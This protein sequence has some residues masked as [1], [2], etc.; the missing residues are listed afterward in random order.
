MSA[1]RALVLLEGGFHLAQLAAQLRR[2][3]R[4]GCAAPRCPGAGPAACRGRCW[5]PCRAGTR[6][7]GRPCASASRWLAFFAMRCVSIMS[8]AAIAFWRAEPPLCTLSAAISSASSCSAGLLVVDQAHRAAEVDQVR[9]LGDHQ[10]RVAL[11]LLPFACRAPSS[12]GRASPEVARQAH[13]AARRQLE[14]QLHLRGEFVAAVA[15]LLEGLE[16]TL[17]GLLRRLGEALR[18]HADL[19]DGGDVDRA[20]GALA[21]VE[22]RPLRRR[23]RAASPAGRSG[24][25][26]GGRCTPG[27]QLAGESSFGFECHVCLVSDCLTQELAVAGNDGQVDELRPG[28]V[29]R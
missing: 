27:R 3:R 5:C 20:E 14:Q 25:A 8:C 2:R 26:A 13:A 6:P 23:W 29:L 11:V 10:R 15:Q 9:L 18:Q 21:R 12:T 1:H 16:V 24:I 22:P 28:M 19:A 17:R 4:A 7:P